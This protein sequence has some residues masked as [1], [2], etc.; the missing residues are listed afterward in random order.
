MSAADPATKSYPSGTLK[1]LPPLILHPF[2]DSSGPNQLMASSRASMMLQ[3]LLPPGDRDRSELDRTLLHGRYQEIR[4]LFYVGRDINR[5]I[6]QCMDFVKRQPDLE[7]AGI[8]PQS[9]AAMLVHNPPPAVEEKLRKWQVGDFRAIFSRALGLN[10]ILAEVP[11]REMLTDDFIRNYYRYAD[12]MFQ[13]RQSQTTFA[14]IADFALD[15]D[16][17]ASGEYS[18]MLEREWS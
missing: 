7:A 10:A 18:R 11:P 5:W 13:C 9:F 3:G 16:I 8:H 12:Q 14:S 4:M 6:D 2:S 1:K 15:F 17:F